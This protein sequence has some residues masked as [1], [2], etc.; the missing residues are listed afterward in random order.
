MFSLTGER[1]FLA[2][3]WKFVIRL[4]LSNVPLFG[5]HFKLSHVTE[6]YFCISLYLNLCLKFLKCL[7]GRILHKAKLKSIFVC[8]CW[9]SSE[10]FFYSSEL[11]LFYGVAVCR[12]KVSCQHL[13]L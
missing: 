4:K 8:T 5:K 2:C 3:S 12:V 7:L 1:E 6:V 11:F 13:H 10:K 9:K